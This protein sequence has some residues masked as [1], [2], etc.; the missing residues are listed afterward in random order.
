MAA[1]ETR[2][3]HFSATQVPIH[4]IVG[5][6]SSLFKRIGVEW[7]RFGHRSWLV[8]DLLDLV[9]LARVELKANW[10]LI[11]R[12]GKSGTGDLTEVRLMCVTLC[13]GVGRVL[14]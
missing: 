8:S 10:R 1:S 11:G 9:D 4:T 13:A 14:D 12:Q 6:R 2:C 3:S 7:I 5:R